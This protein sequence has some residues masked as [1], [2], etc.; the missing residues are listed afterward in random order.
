MKFNHRQKTKKIASTFILILV[1]SIISL[2]IAYAALS[3]TLTISGS[4]TVNASN[5]DINVANSTVY[6]NK[7]TGSATFTTPTISGTTI[8]YSVSL[9]KPGDS[10]T[11]Y[12]DVTN[13]GD[14]LGEITSIVNST[15]TCTSATGNTSDATLVC[16]NLQITMTYADG[17]AVSVGDV[18]N[19]DSYRCTTGTT[20]GWSKTYIKLVISLNSNMSSVPTSQVTLSNLK[21]DILYGQ[22]TKTC[23]TEVCFE[24]GTKVSTVNGYK[25]IEDI[26]VGDLVYSYNLETNKK[27]LKKVV[28]TSTKQTREIYEIRVNNT[29]INSTG[30]H[31][32]YVIDKG[33][34]EAQDLNIKDKLY[35]ARIQFALLQNKN[36]KLYDEEI[37]VYNFTVEDNHNY[38]VSK[39]EILVHNVPTCG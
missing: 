9:T 6:S 39:Q 32:Y 31:P 29:I 22:T 34:V 15:P 2:T 3:E 28:G 36:K 5:W 17:T 37:T 25:N 21:H 18:I 12:F 16:N 24:E 10:V 35:S 1:V 38:F 11:L 33:W 8:S 7:S 27:E 30:I 26:K 4:G 20:S 13:D 23:S 14:I 19:T